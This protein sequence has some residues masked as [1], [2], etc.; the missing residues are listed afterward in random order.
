MDHVYRMK[1]K[2][3]TRECLPI[4]RALF[5]LLIALCPVLISVT[6]ETCYATEAELDLA[7]LNKRVQEVVQRIEPAC[8]SITMRREGRAMNNFSGV[9][10]SEEGHVLTVAHSIQPDTECKITLANG[11][12]LSAKCLGRSTC[13]D[14]GMIII[15]EEDAK[16]SWVEL[17]DSSKLAKH[18]PCISMGHP[19]GFQS[20]RGQVLRFG[21][22]V[23]CNARWDIH[24]T[25]L[26]EPGDSGG[27]LFDLE[28]RLIGIHSY[29][30]KD[31]A[32]NFDVPVNDFR[33]HWEQLCQPSDFGPLWAP[34]R[35]G[36]TLKSSHATKD[37][38]EV[39]SIQKDSP[40]EQ[41]GLKAG[42][43]IITIQGKKLS[44]GLDVEK[45]L[46]N[47]SCCYSHDVS[48]EFLREEKS[49]SVVIKKYVPEDPAV[50]NGEAQQYAE[51]AQPANIISHLESKLDDCVVSVTSRRNDDELAALGTIVCRDG[52]V[53][54]KSTRVDEAPEVSIGDQTFAAEVVLRNPDNDLVLLRVDERFASAVET[55]SDTQRQLGVALIAPRP[56]K[57][58]GR[59]G[60][61]GSRPFASAARKTHGY[62]GVTSM[63]R[64]EVV[65][66]KEVVDGPAKKVGLKKDDIIRKIDDK[67]I[68][69]VNQLTG[70][71]R[72]HAPGDKISIHI[73]RGEDQ[74]VIEVTLGW[75]PAANSTHAASSF[76]G[77]RSNR[78]TGF[79]EVFCHDAHVEPKECGGPLFDLAGNFMGITIARVSRTH[80]YALPA[81]VIHQFLEDWKKQMTESKS[82][83]K[84]S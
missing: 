79:T 70:T 69:K 84:E 76:Q 77:G 12:T 28:G 48:F 17:G 42:D 53:V 15:T 25:C 60:V 20:K 65:V 72:S 37:G 44:E 78:T 8:V 56:N 47:L 59:L 63:L 81:N 54:A 43:R 3:S 38:A 24:N 1:E 6:S 52:L 2:G 74:Q 39:A 4:N 35:F 11:T 82:P 26:M 30:N 80:C 83:P 21:R 73:Q 40:A 68:E 23:G 33:D 9:I 13:L 58:T 5:G 64:D 27:G 14:C 19:R 49:H 50:S 31:L 75:R 41:A 36:I 22:V 46:K 34:E 10:V 61:V 67:E 71:V 29:I 7:A 32:D 66:L 57:E 45:A 55:A 62:L 18:E 16:F 51:L